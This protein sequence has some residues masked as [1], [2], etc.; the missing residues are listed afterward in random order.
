MEVVVTAGAISRA[1][2]QSNHR[3]QQTNTQLFTG[4]MPFLLPNQQCQSTE[5]KISHSMNLLTPSSPL[6]INSSCLLWGGLSCLASALWCQ[7]PSFSEKA[8]QKLLK[9]DSFWPSKS[10]LRPTSRERDIK[11]HLCICV[12]VCVFLCTDKYLKPVLTL[13][14]QSQ[15]ALKDGTLNLTC[16]AVTSSS[17]RSL[18]TVLWKKDHVVRAGYLLLYQSHSTSLSS[19]HE[20]ISKSLL[21]WFVLAWYGMVLLLLLLLLLNKHWLRWR[22]HVKD[23]AG[24]PHNH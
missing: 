11:K 13:H 12:F 9:L 16:A 23:I 15:V 3:H 7:Y 22:S 4:R 20:C 17:S 2:L 24:A 10:H 8:V 14:P 1:K 21:N 19:L 18:V 6:S 5:W